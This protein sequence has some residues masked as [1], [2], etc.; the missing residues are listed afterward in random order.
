VGVYANSKIKIT[1]ATG[2]TIT[3][4]DYSCHV[5]TPSKKTGNCNSMNSVLTMTDSIT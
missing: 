1:F 4:S 3:G 5:M 2:M